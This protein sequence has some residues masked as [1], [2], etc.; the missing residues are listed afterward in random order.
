MAHDR[1]GIV[2]MWDLRWATQA[3]H[4]FDIGSGPVAKVEFSPRRSGCIGVKVSGRDTIDLFSVNEYSSGKVAVSRGPTADAF[5]DEARLKDRYDSDP[6]AQIA[7]A[8]PKGLHIWTQLEGSTLA[9]SRL[10]QGLFLW[11]PPAASAKIAKRYQLATIGSDGEPHASVLPIPRPGAFSCR[12]ALAVAN[13]WAALDGVLASSFAQ[14]KMHHMAVA[15]MHVI[16]PTTGRSPPTASRKPS[17]QAAAAAAPHGTA[18]S[19]LARRQQAARQQSLD[20]RDAGS[21][22]PALGAQPEPGQR[23]GSHNKQ[24]GQGHVAAPV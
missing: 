14:Q 9:D 17:A 5:Q 16:T 22:R 8:P 7:S 23:G 13:N 15:E 6:A 10:L 12:G 20:G 11:V 24:L 19:L 21:A 18:G 1:Q 2:N 3:V 4:R